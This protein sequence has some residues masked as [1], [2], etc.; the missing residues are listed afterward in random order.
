MDGSVLPDTAK[1]VKMTYAKKECDL[2]IAKVT[3]TACQEK[4]VQQCKRKLL[5][6]DAQH[7]AVLRL[8]VCWVSCLQLRVLSPAREIDYSL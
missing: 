4:D 3:Y 2:S 1:L 7:T 8:P 6:C 5:Q